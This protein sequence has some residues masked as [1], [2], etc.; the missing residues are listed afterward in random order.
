MSA[1]HDPSPPLPFAARVLQAWAALLPG[2]V[3]W[4]WGLSWLAPA[5]SVGPWALLGRLVLV[6]PL[7]VAVFLGVTAL[8]RTAGPRLRSGTFAPGS[9][10]HAA[11][12]FHLGLA[13][14]AQLWG[15]LPLLS[16]FYTLRFLRWRALGARVALASNAAF[17]TRLQLLPLL[18][19]G[20]GCTLSYM[21]TLRSFHV[22]PDG[23]VTL[24]PITL[25]EGVFV[26]A[27]S[28]LG[29]GCVVGEGAWIGL[30]NVL[31]H[32]RDALLG[33][34]QPS[35]A[36]PPSLDVPA[37]TQLPDFATS[38]STATTATTATTGT[39]AAEAP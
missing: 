27:D 8:L 24:A 34:A 33:D 17:D 23:R 3:A 30:G 5:W 20:R 2:A 6:L 1:P 16:S 10:G 12:A 32:P 35:A 37:G 4:G 31:A 29:P 11:C 19:I 7:V 18:T 39:A 13:G 25:G 14:S 21:A 15:L 36:D 9:L 26:G 38:S 22:H 28:T